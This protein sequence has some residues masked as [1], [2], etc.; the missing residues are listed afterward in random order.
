MFE[1]RRLSRDVELKKRLQDLIFRGKIAN[2]RLTDML[3]V[4]LFK[5]EHEYCHFINERTISM[6]T[7]SCSTRIIIYVHRCYFIR[8]CR[9]KRVFFVESKSN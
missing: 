7:Y 3:A 4:S 5:P 6:Q 8:F 2:T 1:K 9:D